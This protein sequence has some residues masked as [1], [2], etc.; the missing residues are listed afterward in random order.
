MKKL[1]QP[2][3]N[4]GE[5]GFTLIELLIVIAV[6][7]VLAAVAIPNVMN[8]VISGRLAAAN[9]EAAT[10]GT[11]LQAYAAEHSG[12][13]PVDSSDTTFRAFIGGTGIG[14]SIYSFNSSGSITSASYGGQTFTW[15][16]LSFVR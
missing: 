4:K 7:G 14:S 13:Y 15:N 6:L 2:C 10:V 3:R 11:A 5:K 8:F 1:F 12:S 16:G 9:S